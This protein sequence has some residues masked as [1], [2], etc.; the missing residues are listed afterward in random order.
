MKN[1]RKKQFYNS[2]K[3][4]SKWTE[5]PMGRPI[6]FAD[7]YIYDGS[8]SEKYNETKRKAHEDA[9]RKKARR[10]KALK[11]ALIVVL[12]LVLVSVGYTSMDIFMTR[13]AVPVEKLNLGE[14][15]S[16]TMNEIE[17]SIRAKMIDSI[18]L[19]G[20][21][22]LNSTIN[23]ALTNGFDSVVFDA[24]R[25]DG[26]IGYVSSLASIDTYGAISN[27]ASNPKASIKTLMENDLLPVAKISC[28]RD[29][30]APAQSP[31]MALKKGDSFYTYNESTYLNPN[32]YDTY[33]YIRDIIREL[34]TYGVSVFVLTDCDLPNDISDKYEDGFDKISQRLT[35]ELGDGIKFV[36]AVDASIRG[37]DLE[38]GKTTNSA[39]QKDISKFEK[40][41]KNQIYYVS[42]KLDDTRVMT[43]MNNANIASYIIGD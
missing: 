27:A 35:N 19:D 31:N 42:T 22:M 29:N 26:T 6:D 40:T 12:C 38:S 28:Y 39:I 41:N 14:S 34:N 2:S 36:E 30:V 3:R 32:S 10:Q 17:L 9:I 11:R 20:S 4:N 23:A 43:Q 21:I 18:S 5:E 8:Y 33:C 15:Q 7:K 13:H 16:N 24:K 37:I 25:D 1:K